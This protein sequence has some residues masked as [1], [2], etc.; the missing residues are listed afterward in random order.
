MTFGILR[1]IAT[2]GIMAAVLFMGP[3]AIVAPW[4][5]EAVSAQVPSMVM[6]QPT[7]P[8]QSP[9]SPAAPEPAPAA[10]SQAAGPLPWI[11]ADSVVPSAPGDIDT[12]PYSRFLAAP[13]TDGLTVHAAPGG[14]AFGI[15]P[16]RVVDSDGSDRIWMPVIGATT[17]PWLQVLLPARRNLPSSQAPVNG[18][19]GWVLA[20]D[21]LTRA[22]TVTLD[23]DL[24]ARTITVADAG[25]DLAVFQVSISGGD[26]TARGRHFVMGR[27]ST[28]L[29]QRCSAQPMLILSA[30]SEST[31]GYFDQDS[32]IQAIHAFSNECRNISGYTQAT[33]GCIIASEADIPRILALVP[34]GTPVTV[35]G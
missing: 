23:V 16:A 32:A 5:L 30:Q 6:E 14:P 33:P 19:A 18:A 4:E 8:E 10:A 29:S 11:T 20:S 35:R 2:A 15:L 12:T 28:S 13:K 34:D 3:A 22:S 9:A 24:T 27:Y 1:G 26:A 21:V 25:A 7:A 17:G 31:D